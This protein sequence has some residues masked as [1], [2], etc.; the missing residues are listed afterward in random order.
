MPVTINGT[1]GIA[2]ANGSATTP[3]VQGGDN[4]TGI[5]FPA[6][7]TIAFAEGGSEV[8]RFDSS[9]NLVIGTTTALKR[10]TTASSTDGEGIAIWNPST[11]AT[12]AK[13]T[14]L[15]FYSTDTV[16][17]TKE[18]ASII[19]VLADSNAVNSALS[20]RT[21]G[22]DSN[23]ERMR[24]ASTGDITQ[25]NAISGAG[26][27]V[28]E[29]TFRRTADGTAIGPAIAD[30]FG[31][32]SAISLEALSVYEIIAYLVFTKT[33]AGTITLTMA[34]SSAQNR[35]AGIYIGSPLT[36]IGAG[37]PQWGSAGSQ[38]A[39]TAPFVTTGSLTTGVNH[40]FQLNMQVQTILTSSWRLQITS[41]AGTVTPLAGSYYTVKKI[42]ATTGTFV[43]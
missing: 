18:T 36:G 14:N 39:T 32:T 9:G 10:L 1:T 22:S 16:G 43:S 3:A 29:Q 13:N 19:T 17:T 31:A 4:N 21:R 25:L 20:F 11:G 15:A 7:D 37:S 8:A 23:T 33:T 24:I 28:G 38:G 42:S 5:F 6:A 12:T 40:V 2:G 35:M 41:S 34:A 26:A 30:F 27:I